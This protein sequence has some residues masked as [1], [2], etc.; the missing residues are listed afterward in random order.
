VSA[1][2]ESFNGFKP[3]LTHPERLSEKICHQKIQDPHPGLVRCTDKIRVREFVE[4]RLGKGSLPELYYVSKTSGDITAENI[5]NR[6]FVV[7]TNNGNG[8]VSRCFDRRS[9]DWQACRNLAEKH[10]NLNYYFPY[11]ETQYRDIEPLVF[12]EEFLT[13]KDITS[14]LPD[15]KFFCFDGF[16]ELIQVDLDRFHQHHR[17][18]MSLDWKPLDVTYDDDIPVSTAPPERPV[19]LDD[20]IEAAKTL[21]KGFAFVRVDL[22]QAKERV[23][24]GEMTFTPGAGTKRF[25]PDSFEL[26]LGA[27]WKTGEF[28]DQERFR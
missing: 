3:N 7:Q 19:M 4:S 9:F 11:R 23:V 20:M 27:L 12:A 2:Y 28:V 24:F 18:F 13:S 21:S 5:R 15:Y 8:G 1:Q 6:Q 22:Y 26:E 16:P 17:A 25:L 10:L 14:S